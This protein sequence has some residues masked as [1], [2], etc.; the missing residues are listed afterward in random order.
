MLGSIRP[1][2]WPWPP[3]EWPFLIVDVGAMVVVGMGEAAVPVQVAA[4][5][6]TGPRVAHVLQIRPAASDA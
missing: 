5:Q 6:L 1:W 4:E 2:E 3:W